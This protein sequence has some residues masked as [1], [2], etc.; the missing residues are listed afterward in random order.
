[1]VPL[2]KAVRGA[3]LLAYTNFMNDGTSMMLLPQQ[4]VVLS[5]LIPHER[6]P[7]AEIAVNF[8]AGASVCPKRLS[9]QQTASPPVV[10]PHEW[11]LPAET[12]LNLPA[13][14]SDPL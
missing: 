7:P 5:V 3:W 8:P 13:G 4:T 10:I 12:A 14:A 1:M 2:D 9:P 11:P 6:D